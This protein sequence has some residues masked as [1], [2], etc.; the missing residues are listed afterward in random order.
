METPY[1]SQ[2]KS[3]NNPLCALF[4]R[5]LEPFEWLLLVGAPFLQR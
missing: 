1:S 4:V 5:L 2:H 3:L